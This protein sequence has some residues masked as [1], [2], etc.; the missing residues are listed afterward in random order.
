MKTST[1]LSAPVIPGDDV[2]ELLA[3][4]GGRATYIEW[5]LAAA[6]VFGYAAFYRDRQGD[7]FDFDGLLKSLQRQGKLRREGD[8]VIL[9]VPVRSG[10]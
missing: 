3:V 1:A 6:A 2:L 10:D 8:D 9:S 7:V 5:R 4:G